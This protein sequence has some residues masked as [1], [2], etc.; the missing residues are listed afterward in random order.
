[1]SEV[2]TA[3]TIEITAFSNVTQCGVVQISEMFGGNIHLQALETVIQ[4]L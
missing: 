4:Y 3:I 2:L 1:M